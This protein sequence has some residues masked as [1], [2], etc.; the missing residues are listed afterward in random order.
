MEQ[1]EE[2]RGIWFSV[3]TP[4]AVRNA[5]F[6]AYQTR[7]CDGTGA[8]LRI[9]YGDIVTGESW[10][11]E[12]DV[13]GYVGRSTGTQKVPLL[14]PRANSS[15]G[16]AILDHCIIGIQDVESKDWLY[17][18]ANFTIPALETRAVTVANRFKY[19]VLNA[20]V[21]IATF[22]NEKSAKNY[23]AF[24]RGVRMRVA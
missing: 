1:R 11:E 12:N 10:L 5:L 21:S 6:N 4:V 16:G 3:N 24:M 13:I 15:G 23:I 9:H 20:G 17:K 22:D 2:Y 8:R 14:I 18:A 19:E 7:S